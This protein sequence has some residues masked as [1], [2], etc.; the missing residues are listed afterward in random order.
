MSARLH[1]LIEDI[2]VGR[3]ISDSDMLYIQNILIAALASPDL[4]SEVENTEEY[5]PVLNGTQREFK[6][7]E[8]VMVFY[9]DYWGDGDGALIASKVLEYNP[10]KGYYTMGL[11]DTCT[12]HPDE[13]DSFTIWHKPEHVRSVQKLWTRSLER[14]MQRVK[15][16]L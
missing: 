16:P 10:D 8:T 5:F 4:E 14:G 6:P 12:M 7:G 3:K 13:K 1:G 9:P 2:R 15:N 11:G